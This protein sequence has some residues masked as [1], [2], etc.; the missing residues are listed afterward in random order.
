M[1]SAI[2][3]FGRNIPVFHY[4]WNRHRHTG[5]RGAHRMREDLRV[6]FQTEQMINNRVK[7]WIVSTIR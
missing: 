7:T 5:A 2:V 3:S 6:T 4:S 1:S